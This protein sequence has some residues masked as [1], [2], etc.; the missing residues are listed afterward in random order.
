MANHGVITTGRSVAAAFDDLYY[1][2]R[3]CQ[4]QVLAMATGRPLKRVPAAEVERTRAEFDLYEEQADLHFTALRA[5][6]RERNPTTRLKPAR[7]RRTGLPVRA[8]ELAAA[9]LP[10]AMPGARLG[11]PRRKE[12]ARPREGRHERARSGLR[13]RNPGDHAGAAPDPTTGARATPIYQTTS[14]VFDVDHAASLFNLQRFGNIYSRIT[15]PTVSVLESAS[16]RWRAASRRA[17]WRA[18]TPRSSS[19]SS[20]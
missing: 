16:P 15:N 8:S 20:T 14:F 6:S 17:P 18:A 3:A 10:A 5:C 4:N 1:L 2:E 19:P 11:R 9:R 12:T 7:R 13:L